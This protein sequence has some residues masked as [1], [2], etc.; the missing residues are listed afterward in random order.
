MTALAGSGRSSRRRTSESW[1]AGAAIGMLFVVMLVATWQRWTHPTIDHGR[2]INLPSRLLAGERLYTDISYHYGPFAP[3]FNAGLYRVF[4][5]HVATLHTSGAICALLILLLIYQLARHLM[6]SR[7]ATVTTALV[8]V[9]CA[10]TGFLGNYIQP[11][12]YAALY[13][14]TFALASLL[15]LLRFMA[16]RQPRWMFWAGVSMGAA[17]VCKPEFSVL[18]AVPAAVGWA[19]ASLEQRRCLWRPA[20]LLAIPCLAIGALTYGLLIVRVSWQRLIGE[21]Y[22]MLSQPGLLYFAHFLDGSLQWPSTGWAMLAALGMSLFACGAVALIGLALAPRVESL[23]RGRAWLVWG[24]LAAGWW[25]WSLQARAHGVVDLNPLRGAPVVLAV[26]MASIA[27]T[28]WRAHRRGERLPV[29]QQVL[30]VIAVFSLLSSYRV[31]FNVTLRDFYTP[32]TVPGLI[33]VYLYLFFSVSPAMLLESV[34]CREQA[35]RAA[36]VLI[37]MMVIVLAYGHATLARLRPAF[38]ISAPR[39][40]LVTHPVLG[41]PVA[42]AIGLVIGHTA[43]TDYLVSLP[44]GTIVNFLAERRNPLREESLVPGVLTAERE[45]EAIRRLAEY[46]VP[47]ILIGNLLT[48]EYGAK[49]F[50]VDYDQALVRWIETHYDPIATFSASNNPELRFGDAEFFI[51]AYERKSPPVEPLTKD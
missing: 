41:R 18:C 5:V 50:G 40:Q 9:T 51:R 13:G 47:L 4:G 35:R 48:P 14:W 31:I 2:E 37:A 16:S 34:D 21:N 6:P 15:C 8:L 19:L 28:Q 46:Q 24:S 1:L 27:Y 49:V 10:L 23:W 45:T 32:F 33:I 39:G 3:Y 7:E 26:T 29:Q 25:L 36:V 44:Q 12:A 38:T 17:L 43:P 11:Y 20:W 42:E 30:L 22:T